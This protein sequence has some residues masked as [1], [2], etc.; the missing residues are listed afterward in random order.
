MDIPRKTAARNKKIRRIIYGAVVLAAIPLITLGLSRLKPAAPSVDAGQVWPDVVKRGPMLRS[1][2]GLGTLVPEEIRF[3]PAASSGRVE[4]RL[5]QP[6][7]N[8]SADT[9]LFELSNPELEQQS[10]EAD[11]QLASAQAAFENR[12]VELES[13]IL[14]QQALA[15]TVQA[16]YSQAKLTAESNESLYKQGLLPELQ[17]KLSRTRAQELATRN[18]IEE[19]RLA[20]NT[21]A[22]KTQL[23]VQQ[24]LLDQARELAKLRRRQ[25]EELKVRAGISGVLQE[26]LVQVGQQ[27]EPGTN[28]AR[29]A[30][31][32]RLKADVKIAETQ[33]KDIQIGQTATIDTRNGV[34]PGRVIRIDPAVI[35]GTVTVDI[36]LEGE[37]PRGARPDLSVDGTVELEKLDDVL[38]V[39]RPAFG[40]ENSTVSLF[41]YDPDGKTADRVQVKFGRS[42]VNQIEILEGLR[43]GD[44]VILSDTSQW[45]NVNRIR[46]N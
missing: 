45:D 6:G 44:K 27:V 1:V 32:K 12:K 33:A 43:V 30:D 2:R 25:L 8:V 7:T 36:R 23:A 35:N 46:L 37:L 3:I 20:I 10:M 29:V 28:L 22:L 21:E 13:T 26:V 11:S 31:P 4:R 39:G 16:D 14:N 17:L 18:G 38:Y 34:V 40:T 24:A 9:V 15:A 41:R 5:L 19:K 42:S